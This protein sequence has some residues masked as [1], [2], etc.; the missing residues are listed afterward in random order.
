[1][2]DL[3]AEKAIRCPFQ[4]SQKG[5]EN[6]N[7]D[8]DN[9]KEKRIYII[10]QMEWHCRYKIKRTWMLNTYSEGGQG[11]NSD[12]KVWIHFKY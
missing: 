6:L 4:W 12:C 1:M 2:K 10:S 9:G 3:E 8:N 5:T 7:W 11:I